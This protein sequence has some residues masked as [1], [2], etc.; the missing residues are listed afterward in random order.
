M[1]KETVNCPECRKQCAIGDFIHD[2]DLNLI[3]PHCKGYMFATTP[4]IEKKIKRPESTYQ[5]K[6]P[7][8]IKQQIGEIPYESRMKRDNSH[9]GF[10]SF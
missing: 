4:E 6:E 1:A 9:I 10:G 5:K 8:G 3:C 2:E 7:L